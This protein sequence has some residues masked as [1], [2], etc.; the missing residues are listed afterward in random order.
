MFEPVLRSIPPEYTNVPAWLV[1]G[2][3]DLLVGCSLT[4]RMHASMR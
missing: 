4:A 3:G 2:A 1:L